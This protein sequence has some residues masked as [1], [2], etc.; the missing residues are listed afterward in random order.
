MFKSTYLHK[1]LGRNINK[2][3]EKWVEKAQRAKKDEKEPKGEKEAAGWKL[4]SFNPP[5]PPHHHPRLFNHPVPLIKPPA[6]HYFP[7]FYHPPPIETVISQAL[8]IDSLYFSFIFSLR[9]YEFQWNEGNDNSTNRG[10]G[11]IASSWKRHASSVAIFPPFPIPLFDFI[12]R[13]TFSSQWA[14]MDLTSASL[15]VSLLPN[16]PLVILLTQLITD[17]FSG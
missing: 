15:M 4:T 12:K 7:L 8:S 5:T 9:L 17:A 16:F 10:A 11:L 2:S 1:T 14:G 13:L 6:T 3:K